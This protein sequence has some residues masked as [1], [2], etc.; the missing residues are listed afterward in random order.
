MFCTTG[1]LFSFFAPALLCAVLLC[2]RFRRLETSLL[3]SE[4]LL[5][6][7]RERERVNTNFHCGKIQR[8]LPPGCF[9]SAAAAGN[10]SS[11]RLLRQA[12][13]VLSL[14]SNERPL[15]SDCQQPQPGL[16]PSAMLDCGSLLL[17]ST[18]AAAPC[19][20]VLPETLAGRCSPRH[21]LQVQLALLREG[22]SNRGHAVTNC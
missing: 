8:A 10:R 20:K 2:V 13:M 6:D 15:G 19:W 9:A 12:H 17:G 21:A 11:T 7:Q 16:A 3:R 14:G 4:L 22:G 5:F 1:K 18:P